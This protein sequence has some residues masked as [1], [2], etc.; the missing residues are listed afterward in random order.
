M[1]CENNFWTF[2]FRDIE[3]GND[4]EIR[5]ITMNLKQSRSGY[6]FC[7]AAFSREIGAMMEEESTDGGLLNGLFPVDVCYDGQPIKRLMF[8]PDW[9]DYA[10]KRTHIQ[11]HDIHKALAETRVDI[12]RDIVE[13]KSIYKEIINSTPNTIIP[14]IGDEN[15]TLSEGQVRK[16]Y[17]NMSDLSLSEIREMEARKDERAVESAVAVD[18]D[19]ITAEQAVA[20]LNSMFYVKTW[21]TAN[22]ELRIG[23]PEHESIDHLAAE[24]D[25]RIWRYKNP[26]I[27]HGREPIKQALVKGPFIDTPGWDVGDT[28]GGIK[29]IFG[30]EESATD[31]VA[32]GVAERT[33]IDRGIRFTAEAPDA[34]RSSLEKIAGDALRE[35]VKQQKSGQVEIDG[36]LS[37]VEQSHPVDARPGDI[38]NLIPSDEGFENPNSYSGQLGDKPE[39]YDPSCGSF[40]YNESYL[41]TEVEQNLTKSGSWNTFLDIADNPNISVETSIA[42]YNPSTDDWV[43]SSDIAENGDLKGGWYK[44]EG[45]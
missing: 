22:G 40:V 7:R 1:A 24:R 3:S 21:S 26:S 2:R 17:G 18:F 42:Y 33:D 43:E 12:K 10:N 35:K 32:Y 4:F 38:I 41:I 19:E 15:F 20:E 9:V 13:L 16:L 36:D 6:D 14:E 25:N 45:V 37:G 39:D 29:A 8:R 11:F 28:V 23:L 44:S 5:P 27:S 31:V 30:N 34:K